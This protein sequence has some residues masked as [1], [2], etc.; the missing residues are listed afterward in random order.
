MKKIAKGIAAV[1]LLTGV[2]LFLFLFWRS[3]IAHGGHQTT[4]GIFAL[5]L[6]WAVF[7]GWAMFVSAELRLNLVL[8]QS[9][10]LVLVYSA[11][12]LYFS[13]ARIPNIYEEVAK[14]F[15]I[16]WDTRSLDT[17]IRDLATRGVQAYPSMA[18]HHTLGG[19]SIFLFSG[20]SLAPTVLCNESGKWE[21][22]TTDRYGFN[23]PDSIWDEEEIEYVLV[24][25]SFTHGLC[26]QQGEDVAG[27]LMR[28]TGKPA[29]NL[30]HKGL[31]PIAE[32]AVIKE[33]GIHIKPKKILW[34]YYEGNDLINNL[35]GEK[36]YPELTRY[37]NPSYSQN[38]VARQDEIDAALISFWT[39]AS[40]GNEPKFGLDMLYEHLRLGSMRRIIANLQRVNP[41]LGDNTV[42]VDPMFDEVLM[43]ARDIVDGWGGE[44]YFVY[45]PEYERYK[46]E[47]LDHSVHRKRT[48]V[49]ELV[50]SLDIP[51]ID[52]HEQ[53]FVPQVDPTSLFPFGLTGHYSA[54]GYRQVAHA[55]A[56]AMNE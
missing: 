44:L 31:G 42:V 37:L 24:G 41:D 21:V 4:L 51:I 33:Y 30:G 19:E 28:L 8:S 25:D 26:V 32:Y 22:V 3:E 11:E 45:L 54:E 23:N 34:L 55:L 39:N 20:I 5:V 46:P 43:S 35:G 14:E 12:I 13:T 49:L 50:I 16:V 53:V 10:V 38:L 56:V 17:V 47:V 40:K 6:A 27:Q 7:W 36:D 1:Y 9:I 48:D 2:A 29:L 52:I 15:G 18:G